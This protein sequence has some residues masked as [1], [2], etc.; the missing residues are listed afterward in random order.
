MIGSL[1][2]ALNCSANSSTFSLLNRSTL[3]FFS[4]AFFL[5]SSPFFQKSLVRYVCFPQKN[6]ALL[7]G[8]PLLVYSIEVAI[9]SHIFDT[10]CVSSENEEILSIAFNSEKFRAG[11]EL[12]FNGLQRSGTLAISNG[13]KCTKRYKVEVLISQ[14]IRPGVAGLVL[15]TDV[16]PEITPL[17][18][19]K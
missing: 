18:I 4:A 9:K 15:W 14:P 10:I 12:F 1:Y 19:P 8:K 16:A 13:S 11:A 2:I 3:P 5:F 7:C 17:R 6:I